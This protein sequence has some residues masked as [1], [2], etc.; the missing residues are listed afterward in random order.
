MAYV[1]PDVAA[2]IDRMPLIGRLAR[3]P[4]NPLA[5]NGTQA[6]PTAGT[7]VAS[8]AA[9]PAGKYI[10]HVFSRLTGSVDEVQANRSNLD[11]RSSA[12]PAATLASGFQSELGGRA[13]RAFPFELT[14]ASTV[15]V[16]AVANATASTTYD[17]TLILERVA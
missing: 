5:V 4:A 17:V 3:G 2:N 6:A 11:L 7:S 8:L 14:G 12:T 1:Y 13:Y 10:A 9:V 15:A 16:K